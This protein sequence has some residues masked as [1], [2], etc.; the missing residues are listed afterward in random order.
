MGIKPVQVHGFIIRLN[1]DC[2][3]INIRSNAKEHAGKRY[4]LNLDLKDFFHSITAGRVREIFMSDPFNFPKDLASLLAIM[5]TWYN[6]L[7]MGAPTSPVLS[8]LACLELDN[9]L[10]KIAEEYEL[11]YSRYADDLT[12][13][14][15]SYP[16]KLLLNELKS[17]I[18]SEGFQIN[19]KK[20]R[21]QPNSRRQEVTGITVNEKPNLPRKYYRNL[22]SI[23][24]NW[25]H[26]GLEYTVARYYNYRALPYTMQKYKF[27][28]SLRT[29]IEYLEYIRG[30]NDPLA[31]KLREHYYRNRLGSQ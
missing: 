4:L 8:N 26:Y 16:D 18:E 21:I 10:I 23:L 19:H 11:T 3:L 1:D 9:K 13:S 29:R 14:G 30:K 6:R 7:P 15:N 17:A 12:F 27:L 22:R 20:F 24:Y 25:E 2:P 31:N 28:T 5:T